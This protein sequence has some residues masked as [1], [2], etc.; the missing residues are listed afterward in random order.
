MGVRV[1]L[2]MHTPLKGLMGVDFCLRRRIDVCY[3]CEL[4]SEGRAEEVDLALLLQKQNTI[5]QCVIE[6][7]FLHFLYHVENLI[8]PQKVSCFSALNI[9]L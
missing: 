4:G 8:Q 6:F 7:F 2:W 3:I 5:N 9:V 1:F